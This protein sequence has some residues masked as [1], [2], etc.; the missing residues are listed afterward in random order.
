MIKTGSIKRQKD[1]KMDAKTEQFV[2]LEEE[3]NETER[4]KK[5]MN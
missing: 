2:D 5:L 3:S 4:E 1:I